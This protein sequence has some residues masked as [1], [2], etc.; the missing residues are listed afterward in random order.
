MPLQN[1]VDPWGIISAVS[2]RGTLLGNRG[3]L[4]NEKRQIVKPYQ[5]QS[6]VT[7]KLKFKDRRRKL[8]SQ[9][10]YT[11]LFF[12]D[13]STAFAAGHRPCCECRRERYT[14]FKDYWARA[15]LYKYGNDIKISIIN[16]IMHKERIKKRIK[17]TYKSNIKDLPDGTIFSSNGAAYL[18]F[19]SKIYFWSFEGYSLQNNI[20]FPGKVDILTPKSIINA[21]KLGFK[22]EVH[23]SVFSQ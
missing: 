8:M 13:E 9:G 18:I 20:Y 14:E 12:L 10:T 5:H 3:I 21:F 16:K 2:A 6:W 15:N 23:K 19:K 1:R 22:P 7:C 4:H 11:E 17:I